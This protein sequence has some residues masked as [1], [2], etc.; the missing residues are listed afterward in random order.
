MIA[1]LL[2]HVGLAQARP[3]DTKAEEG[4]RPKRE[5][6]YAPLTTPLRPK[7]GAALRA[8]HYA[9]RRVLH[10]APLTMPKEGTCTTRRS[11]RP[12]TT[13]RGVLAWY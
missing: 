6:H 4:R 7:K 10:Y 12:K 9:Q 5:L 1:V 11:L 8:A 13:H 3:N 2:L